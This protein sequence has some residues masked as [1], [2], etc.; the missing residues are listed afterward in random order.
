[1]VTD[2]GNLYAPS[3]TVKHNI[4][5]GGPGGVFPFMVAFCNS[6]TM[7]FQEWIQSAMNENTESIAYEHHRST[8]WLQQLI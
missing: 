4:R 5:Q 1:M 6:A 3:T 7:I 8:Q 2:I